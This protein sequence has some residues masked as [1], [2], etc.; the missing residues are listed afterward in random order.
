MH[1]SWGAAFI[2]ATQRKKSPLSSLI[3]TG[4]IPVGEVFFLFLFVFC[5]AQ[6]S[7]LFGFVWENIFLQ[8]SWR[9]SLAAFL[10]TCQMQFGKFSIFLPIVLALKYRRVLPGFCYCTLKFYLTRRK[11]IVGVIRLKV[12]TDFPLA[13]TSPLSPLHVQ[14]CHAASVA[15]T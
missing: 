2:G 11:T 12:L 9:L 4:C 6:L 1:S 5:S 7:P 14:T 10:S 3:W 8:R 15:M 13:Q